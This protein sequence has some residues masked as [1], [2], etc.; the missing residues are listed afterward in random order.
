MSEWESRM[1]L[2]PNR[3]SSVNSF[4][5]FSLSELRKVKSN[6]GGAGM[7]MTN[8]PNKLFYLLLGITCLQVM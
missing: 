6:F 7:L 8:G 2:T 5:G 1:S 4:C 3:K